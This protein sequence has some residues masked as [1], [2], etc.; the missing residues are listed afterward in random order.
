MIL[1]SRSNRS[2]LITVSRSKNNMSTSKPLSF[3]EFVSI[4][5]KVPRLGIDI[6]VKKNNGIVFVKRNIDPYKDMWH[7]P[8][9]TLLFDETIDGAVSRIVQNELN[10]KVLSKKY[11]GIIEY[12]SE[13]DDRFLKKH[14]HTV[15]LIFLVEAEG[16]LKRDED[17]SEVKI[18][19]STPKNIIPEQKIFLDSHQEIFE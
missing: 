4:Y 10:L 18:L 1:S 3:E 9:S 5:S 16:N 14:R 15:C 2:E 12:L 6:I 13:P 11:L 7:F 8:G 17:A 19:K